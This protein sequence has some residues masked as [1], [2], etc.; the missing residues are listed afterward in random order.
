MVSHNLSQIQTFFR[1]ETK[2][3]LHLIISLIIDLPLYT[4]SLQHSSL[5]LILIN[6]AIIFLFAKFHLK[7]MFVQ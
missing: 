7:N 2:H 5:C 3:D 6:K 4:H 1:Y